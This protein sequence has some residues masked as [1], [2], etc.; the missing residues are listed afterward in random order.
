[1]SMKS[2]TDGFV[3]LILMFCQVKFRILMRIV[4]AEKY[5][6]CRKIQG[7]QK[8]GRLVNYLEDK[9]WLSKIIQGD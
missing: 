9:Y 7:V 6:L 4:G 1:M 5:W 3:R 8:F 2:L